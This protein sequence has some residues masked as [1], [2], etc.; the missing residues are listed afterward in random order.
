MDTA[1]PPLD[2][3]GHGKA[4]W[5]SWPNDREA[6]SPQTDRMYLLHQLLVRLNEFPAKVFD[7]Y[8]AAMVGVTDEIRD[9]HG[10][11]MMAWLELGKVEH[12]WPWADQWVALDE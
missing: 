3:T 6:D 2:D 7:D 10:R 11:V 1:Y 5:W 4:E 9:A 12:G 8:S